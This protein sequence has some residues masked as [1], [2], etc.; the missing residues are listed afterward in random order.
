MKFLKKVYVKS[1][2]HTTKNKKKGQKN[3]IRTLFFHVEKKHC[4]WVD[5]VP[6][7][8]GGCEAGWL[9]ARWTQANSY[10]PPATTH[11][12]SHQLLAT[13][14]LGGCHVAAETVLAGS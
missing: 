9:E 4:V 6:G 2:F 14:S 12:T 5:L 10:W 13:K 8:L 1:G 7:L 11:A 3:V